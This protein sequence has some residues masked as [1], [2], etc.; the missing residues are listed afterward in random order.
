MQMNA[1]RHLPRRIRVLATVAAASA[2]AIAGTAALGTGRS[3]AQTPSGRTI[4]VFEP[5]GGSTFGFV[6]N[7]PTTTRTRPSLSVGDSLA[8][9]SRV[10]DASRT[11]RLGTSASQCTVTQPGGLST[12]VK[13]C[14]GTFALKG[15]T[16]AVAT[17]IR[18]EPNTIVLA[19]T[20]GTGA[21]NGA[22]GT[23]TSRLSSR[24][25]ADTF[26]LMP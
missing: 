13:T 21:Y 10:L 15:G 2:A 9:G 16:L 3:S 22:R 17:E 11:R 23:M 25:S 7:P 18:G 19:V 12:A 8:F 20:G 5:R 1:H 26:V 4:T 14:F 6:D 24:G